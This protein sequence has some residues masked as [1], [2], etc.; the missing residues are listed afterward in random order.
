MI[1]S[2]KV[3]VD[4]NVLIYQAFSLFDEKK[5]QEVQQLL[6]E[7][8]SNGNKLCIS[9]QILRE[10]YSVATN[11][12]F[13]E[14]P[15]TVVEVIERIKEYRRHFL[16]LDDAN[17][18]DLMPLAERY[19]VTKRRIH[20]ANLVATMLKAGIKKLYTYNIK[21]FKDFSEVELVNVI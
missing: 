2:S 14:D 3:F 18:D 19:A 13:F 16:V 21:D 9:S 20:D 7:L 6:P 17:I 1:Q 5:H 4:T 8:L 11:P 10:F 15:L 12:K